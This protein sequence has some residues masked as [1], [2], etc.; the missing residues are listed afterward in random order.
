MKDFG[1]ISYFCRYFCGYIFY[2]PQS[3]KKVKWFCL[4]SINYIDKAN[5]HFTD[6]FF[7]EVLAVIKAGTILQNRYQI[8]KQIGAGGM[9][10]VYLA[11]DQ[12]FGS[13]LAIKENFFTDADLHRAFERE[14]QLLNSLRH[15]ALPRVSDYF[16]E[17]N[18]HF[19]VM[20][21]IAGEDLSQVLDRQG[22]FAVAD[23]LQWADQLLDALDYLHTQKFPV[24]HRDIKPQNLKLTRR[25]QIILLDFG[26]AKGNVSDASRFSQAS[27]VFGYSR[28]YAPLEQIQGAGTDQRS[29]LYSLSATLYH[30]VTGV[31]PPDALARAAAVVNNQPDPL[32]SVNKL[33]PKVPASVAK[34]LHEA[35]SLN[36]GLR[37]Q[38][39]E[40][41]RNMLLEAV[42]KQQFA[43]VEQNKIVSVASESESVNDFPDETKVTRFTDGNQLLSD[44]VFSSNPQINRISVPIETP[45]TVASNNSEAVSKIPRRSFLNPLGI[46][47][48]LALLG[49]GSLA[50]LYTFSG[51]PIGGGDAVNS[52]K[53]S[54]A[55]AA[56][57]PAERK[58]DADSQKSESVEQAQTLT[59]TPSGSPEL[60]PTAPPKSDST[61][62]AK[63]RTNS[64][65][66]PAETKAAGHEPIVEKTEKSGATLTKQR[67]EKAPRIQRIPTNDED[68]FETDEQADDSRPQ[69]KGKK[70]SSPI[71]TVQGVE[72]MGMPEEVKRELMRQIMKR[73][74]EEKP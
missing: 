63:G 30:L 24:I 21:Y 74:K 5:S 59:G 44:S 22:A 73:A 9:G 47:V 70:S 68:V 32:R 39:A 58:P 19:L 49:S 71:I 51:Y 11:T 69:T 17:G 60:P 54:D 16:E 29:D 36:A 35:M 6:K 57:N 20:E 67:Q 10:A 34:V 52:V 7:R 66:I 41:M 50:S 55:E 23:I 37:P 46:V 18:G 1:K 12:R 56:R 53:Q 31:T 40:A 62:P 3:E 8:Q 48:V 25:N 61:E 72:R 28:A 65:I 13:L 33:N 14:A 15:P 2:Y 26:L 27:S 45:I 42:D 38:T 43:Q 64:P 4:S